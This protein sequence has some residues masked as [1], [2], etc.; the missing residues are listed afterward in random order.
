MTNPFFGIKI[1]FDLPFQLLFHASSR[2]PKKK[3]QQ[4]FLPGSPDAPAPNR[5]DPSPP[6]APC[7]T[8]AA[9]DELQRLFTSAIAFSTV[10]I[11]TIQ[12][13]KSR[14]H[15]WQISKECEYQKSI[16]TNSTVAMLHSYVTYKQLLARINH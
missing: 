8:S 5:P 16:G 7:G 15:L 2:H 10:A 3:N 4:H 14:I 11:Q 6:C 1:Q 13:E 9:A 12:G